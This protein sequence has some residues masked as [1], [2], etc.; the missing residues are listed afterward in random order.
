MYEPSEPDAEELKRVSTEEA[1]KWSEIV[2][3][4]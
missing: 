1:L 2:Q 4:T 3:D